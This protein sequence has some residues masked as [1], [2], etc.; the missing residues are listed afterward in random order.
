MWL[1]SLTKEIMKN[2][3]LPQY[4]NWTTLRNKVLSSPTSGAISIYDSLTTTIEQ[5]FFVFYKTPKNGIWLVSG[6]STFR[7]EHLVLNKGIGILLDN[8]ASGRRLP[9]S[10][11]NFVRIQHVRIG[12]ATNFWTLWYYNWPL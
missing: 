4:R 3:Y 7:N 1:I 6:S 10:A 2:I 12:G 11:I 5:K 9:L 8:Y